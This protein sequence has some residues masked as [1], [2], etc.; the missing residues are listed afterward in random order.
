MSNEKL[1]YIPLYTGDWEKD[2][3][4]LSLQAEGAWL[5]IIFKMFNNG[6][7]SSYKIPTKGLQNLWR[8]PEE[9]VDEIIQELIDYNIC[10]IEFE[11][12]FVI[13]TSRRYEREN[14]ISDV[15]RKAVSKRKDRAGGLQTSYKIDTKDIQ[16]H[17]DEY[18]VDNVVKKEDPLLALFD[19][20][21]GMFYPVVKD[22]FAYKKERRESY[23]SDQSKRAF[24]T[25]LKNLSG[26]KVEI[27]RKIIEQSMANN[28]AGIF[29]LKETRQRYEEQPRKVYENF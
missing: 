12:R 28:W 19:S 9:V 25:K 24:I 14:K 4:V 23:K 3:N 5:R 8:V 27:A 1:P 10:G 11:G 7:Q 29:E 21:S 6:K 2:C 18:E 15:R 17:E 22:W 26:G 20:T 13:F 16:I